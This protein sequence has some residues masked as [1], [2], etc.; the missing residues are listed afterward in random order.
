MLDGLILMDLPRNKQI[1]V[2]VR[3]WDRV[4]DRVRVRGSIDGLIPQ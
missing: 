1:R 3:V 2:G 4:W